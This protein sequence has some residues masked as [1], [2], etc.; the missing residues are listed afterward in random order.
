MP[1][2]GPTSDS[3]WGKTFTVDTNSYS[4]VEVTYIQNQQWTSEGTGSTMAPGDEFNL[5]I[6]SARGT[7]SSRYRGTPDNPSGEYLN[8]GGY[9]VASDGESHIL[10]TPTTASI[11][12]SSIG[13]KNTGNQTLKFT[14]D[15]S[16]FRP[17]CDMTVTKMVL[18][19]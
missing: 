3:Q 10:N 19:N 16:S 5:N 9:N 12:L 18:K 15:S 1:S 14:M 4:K 11:S 7:L 17:T 8:C 2:W 6:G 13:V